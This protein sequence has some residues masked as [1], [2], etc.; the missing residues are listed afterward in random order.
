VRTF[1][2][3]SQFKKD[4]KRA[5]SRGKEMAKLKAA[6]E[7][8]IDG[9]PLCLRHTATIRCAETLRA[10]AIATWSRIGF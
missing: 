6:M 5:D 8:L 3:T 1:S 10:A 2:R 7:L 4:V 9:A